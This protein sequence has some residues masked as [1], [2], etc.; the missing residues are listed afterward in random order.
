MPFSGASHVESTTNQ[1]PRNDSKRAEDRGG[2]PA[3]VSDTKGSKGAGLL[4]IDFP[5]YSGE[6][7]LE[8]ISWDDFFDKFDR[9]NIDFL[10]QEESGEGDTSRFCKFV[11]AGE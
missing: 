10:Y 4:R 5:D 2:H 3:T 9:E 6:E 1:R 11:R 8:R 7:T